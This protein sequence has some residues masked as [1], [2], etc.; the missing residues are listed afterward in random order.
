MTRSAP[1]RPR[2]RLPVW[3]YWFLAI[4]AG[5]AGAVL[6]V[7]W[8]PGGFPDEADLVKVSGTVERVVVRD[9]IGGSRKAGAIL[10]AIASVYFTLEGRDQAFRYPSSHPRYPEVRDY[11][12]AE[13]DVWVDAAALDADAP[14]IIWRLVERNPYNETLPATEIGYDEIVAHV[15]R[16]DRSVVE[17]GAWLLAGAAVLAALGLVVGRLNR[18]RVPRA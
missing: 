4:L 8:W 5:L 15:T 2:Y 7:G 14:A 11:V 9:D 3:P 13:I 18:G 1:Q 17:A 12:A 16:A 6:V 10:P